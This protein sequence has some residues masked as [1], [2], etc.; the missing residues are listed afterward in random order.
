MNIRRK[1]SIFIVLLTVVAGFFLFVYNQT[2]LAAG[3]A[4]EAQTVL[5]ERGDNALVVG[6]KLVKAHMI[7][8]KY[9]LAF[10][11]WKNNQLHNLVAGVYVFQPGMKIP[12]IAKIITGGETAPTA[13]PITFPEG[14]TAKDMAARL[15]ANGLSGSDFLKIVNDPPQDLIDKYS[16]LQN[17][18]KS[19]SLEGYL[20][21]D[22]YYFA[23]D[24]SAQDVAEKMLKNFGSKLTVSMQNEII[25]K[26][27]TIFE[28]VTL[29]SVIEK[30]ARF[31]EDM[32][33]VASVFY[34]RL[35]AGQR[36]ES[37]AT[38]EYVL[39]DNKIQHSATDLQNSSPYNTYRNQGLPPGPVSN[40][41]LDAL[42]AAIFPAQ[43]DYYF[44]L[45]D[46]KTKQTIFSK[47]F[48]EHV[49]NKVKYGL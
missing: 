47:T 8:G 7:A 45:T 40:P 33:L 1:I 15:D 26:K 20:F 11:L 28:I 9:Y 13:I 22:T 19:A 49:A 48:N 21:P 37:D 6:D 30:E 34:N 10:Y 41:G 29:A 18:P 17:F 14:W 4:S 24:A 46:L 2:Y 38:L 39:Q 43:T 5:V 31:P 23:K 16:F 35:A 25:A 36:L 3:T 42:S 12:E 32:K 27:R 44:F